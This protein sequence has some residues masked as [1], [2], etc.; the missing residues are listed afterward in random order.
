MCSFDVSLFTN[1]PIDETI[2]ICLNTLYHSDM[3]PPKISEAL[4]K[5]LLLKATRGVEFSFDNMMY[6][7]I[8]GVAMGPRWVRCWLTSFLDCVSRAFRM[9]NGHVCTGGL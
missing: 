9:T 2:E 5:K 3:K 4:L 1:V 7:Q 8:D 6:R